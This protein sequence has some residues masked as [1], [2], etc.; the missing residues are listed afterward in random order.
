MGSSTT[1]AENTLRVIPEVDR[2]RTAEHA[3]LYLALRHEVVMTAR[4]STVIDAA[5]PVPD[6]SVGNIE[7]TG[8]NVSV[9]PKSAYE[10]SVRIVVM[11]AEMI[12]IITTIVIKI[13]FNC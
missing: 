7:H 3:S 5:T 4:T 2:I 1:H 9:K 10:C 6:I 8:T 12:T 11:I 13:Q